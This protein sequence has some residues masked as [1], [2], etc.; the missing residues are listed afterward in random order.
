M[1][2]RHT[3]LLI[4][5]CL[6]A[7]AAHGAVITWDGGSTVDS[8]WQT[9]ANWVGDAPPAA[10]DTLVFPAGAA[11]P[12]NTN[13]FAAGTSFYQLQLTGG[14]YTLGGNSLQLRAM[15]SGSAAYD[16][17]NTGGNNTINLS[18][19]PD[20]VS[21]N[22]DLYFYIGGAGGTLTVGAGATITVPTGSLTIN[23]DQG[24]GKHMT[25]NGQITGAGFMNCWIDTNMLILGNSAND[26]AGAINLSRGSPIRLGASEVLPNGPG[27]G[28]VTLSNAGFVVNATLDLYGYN[29]TINGLSDAGTGS[30]I[31]DNT[32]AGTASRLTVGDNNATSAFGGLLTDTGAGATLAL[33]KTGTGTFTLTGTANAYSGGTILSQGTIEFNN[34]SALG[35][36]GVTLGDAGTGASNVALLATTAMTINDSLTVSSLGAGTATIG[37]T[38]STAG[39]NRQFGGML[40]LS[41]DV[42]LQAGASDR[43]T[44]AGQITGTGDITV[45]SPFA[46]NRRIVFDRPSGAANNFVGDIYLGP[47]A[48]L[49]IGVANSIGNRTVPDASGIHFAA[50]SRFRIAPSGSDQETV[51]PLISD[52]PGAGTVDVYTGGAT[53]TLT[54][55]GGNGSGDYS[56][57]IINS[58]GSLALTKAGSGTQTLSGTSTYTGATTVNAG[59]L[60]IVGSIASPV[61]VAGGW[62]GGSGTIAGSVD[63][64]AAGGVS[65]GTSPGHL[66]ILG[67]YTQSGTLLAELGGTRQGTQYDWIEVAGAATL[68][69]LIDVDFVNSFVAA[70][71]MHF[72][73]LTAAGGITNAD[74]G[75]L[76][77]DFS[78]A[79]FGWAWVPE[80]VSLGGG[81]EALRLNA[82][83]EPAT[84]TL[85]AL[86]GLALLR[87]RRTR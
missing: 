6:V 10:G 56:G 71:G 75:G 21:G 82:S 69:G 7:A 79:D 34:A 61:T 41:R 67:G 5:A 22:S 36:A 23:S 17:W 29:E 16:V 74:L 55:G 59:T 3:R 66:L 76:T 83:P 68:G 84:L 11:R 14:G 52:A 40:T 87:R 70:P 12:S 27:K 2:V 73:I 51:G 48:D 1:A 63:I 85:L 19:A 37:S 57:R 81:A 43:T 77:F 64:Q 38:N 20:A 8:N 49:Q 4:L 46:S 86:G 47:N 44:F 30:R 33:T 31:V 62:L 80:I 32:R 15:G 42:T 24:G 78:G 58:S 72:D 65:A 54:I 35:S 25:I 18:V 53:F 60:L 45:S 50:G 39:L 26:W 28:N 13:N 9:G